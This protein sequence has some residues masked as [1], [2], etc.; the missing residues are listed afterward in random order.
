MFNTS[1]FGYDIGLN[2][3]QILRP[4]PKG[5]HLR[6]IKT[7][8]AMNRWSFDYLKRPRKRLKRK[9]QLDYLSV[10]ND[11]KICTIIIYNNNVTSKKFLR[12]S[13][14]FAVK[15]HS[16]AFEQANEAPEQMGYQLN[17]SIK[18]GWK[19]EKITKLRQ[20]KRHCC[21]CLHNDT[22]R[23]L[24]ALPAFKKA[25]RQLRF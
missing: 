4:H 15:C 21:Y 7:K 16:F 19:V 11:C 13:I 18:T 5:V 8:T 23:S 12:C 6:C 1:C 9:H 14:C 25:V 3:L 20:R 2:F 17:L 24:S 22:V 10:E